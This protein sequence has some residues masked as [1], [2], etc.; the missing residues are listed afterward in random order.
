[1]PHL[2]R[3]PR[4]SAWTGLLALLIS[5]VAIVAGP[6]SAASSPPRSADPAVGI[7][8]SGLWTS[9]AQ[10]LLPAKDGH[11]RLVDPAEYSGFTLDAAGMAGRLAL[12]PLEDLR[13]PGRAGAVTI[14]VPGPTGELIDFAVVESSIMEP[15]L[16]ARNPDIRTYA[17]S[18]VTEGYTASIRLDMTPFGFH[19]SVRDGQASWYVDPA[20]LGDTSLYVSYFGASLPRPE[21]RLVEPKIDDATLEAVGIDP[22]EYAERAAAQPRTGEGPD[23]VVLQRVYR[24]ALTTDASYAEFFAPGLNV[25][26]LDLE[27]SNEAVFAAKTTLM[28]RVNH[29]YNDDLAIKMIFVDNTDVLLNLNNAAREAA[30]GLA[31]VGQ[32]GCLPNALVQNQVAVD[33]LIGPLN[34]DIG[35]IALGI[36]GG[37]V[38]FLGVVGQQGQKAG[39]CTGLAS[40]VGDFFAI[41]Y[42]AHEMGH[43]FAGPHTFNGTQ[44]NCADGNRT[45]GS[46]V[47]PGSGSSVMAYAGICAADDLQPHTDP[48]FSQRTQ[49]E[50]TAYV[51]SEP[52]LPVGDTR[53]G[54]EVVTTTNR[55]P[56]VTAPAD[57]T[58]P[59][60][61]PFTL[62]GSATDSDGDEL[63][64][65]W[66]QN[67]IGSDA[68][69]QLTSNTKPDGPLFRVLSKFADVSDTDTLLYNSPGQNL[70][71]TSPVRS[72]PDVDQIIAGHTNAATGTCPTPTDADY[73]GTPGES[74]LKNGP[75]LDC[76]SEFLPTA[77]Y[78]GSAANASPPRL[79]FRLTARDL[80]VEGGGTQF[81]DVTL[82]VDPSA[83]PFLVSSQATPTTYAGGSTQTVTWAVNNTAGLAPNVRITMSTDGGDTFGQVLAASTPNDGSHDVVIP[84]VA[85]TEGWIKVEAVDNVFFD[86]N[87]APITVPSGLEVVDPADAASTQYSDGVDITFSAT[88]DTPGAD[89]AATPTGLPAGLA[90]AKTGT[91]ADATWSVTGSVTDAPGT[92]PV[93][94]QVSD[95]TESDTVGFTITVTR[96]GA[97]ATYTG[98]ASATLANAADT[99]AVVDLTASVVAAAD[100][101]P[102]DISTARATFTDTTTDD[103]LCADVVVTATATAGTGT[104]ACSAELALGGHDVVVTVGGRYVGTS[105]AATVSVGAPEAPETTLTEV[106]GEWNLAETA[107]F[108]FASSVPGSTFTCTLDGV[109]EPCTSPYVV[110]GLS[111]T[112]HTFS[113]AAA[114]A[115]VVDA[116]PATTRTTV[117]KAARELKA[118]TP[119]WKLTRNKSAYLGEYW[120]TNKK[121]QR[122]TY[123]VSGARVLA[124][125]VGT[126]P[127]SGRI[128]VVFKG[129]TLRVVDLKGP[130]AS[131]KVIPLASFA[132]PTTGKLKVVTLTKQRRSTMRIEGLGVSTLP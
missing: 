9:S 24:L 12:A 97:S 39:G 109:S 56:V 78:V 91:G 66:E 120:R 73:S 4:T 6:P 60:R 2:R 87:D 127:K 88:S 54:F 99:D 40:P 112:T 49:E 44:G 69:V 70:A 122:L 74:P 46:S 118:K 123:R 86:L 89:L 114:N 36:D 50:I 84:D 42:V 3:G 53:G 63:I 115:G 105:P 125:V 51:T 30:A 113:V 55:N 111:R 81:D 100:G 85:T 76:Y 121:G 38:A 82:T 1:V 126:G 131:K 8:P 68:G 23:G 128:K 90:L 72:F 33:T 45:G 20:Y 7:D 124:L 77:D 102:G 96:E 15:A 13:D 59:I 92:Y 116:T 48:Y 119:G 79:N 37:G 41:D 16:Q 21:R 98:P 94:V 52:E 83:G 27:A 106:P 19:A 108:S 17:G 80:T 31:G 35:H 110:T 10:K 101:T 43:Q 71:T 62:S 132:V 18:S 61:T 103:V 93:S 34:Y 14:S 95:G 26:P 107:R 104:A 64:Y 22:E 29:I 67:D 65:L 130:R 58:I 117:P 129:K 47:E 75:V 28:N 5:T 25:N 32:T 11:R 57:R